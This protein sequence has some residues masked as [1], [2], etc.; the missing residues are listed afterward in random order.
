[1]NSGE[2]REYHLLFGRVNLYSGVTREYYS[3]VDF[4]HNA[5]KTPIRDFKCTFSLIREQYSR[6]T[7]ELV[8]MLP[9]YS[10]V[11]NNAPELLKVLPACVLNRK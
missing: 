2:T 10:R 1:M 11:G 7:P 9:N 8:I 6:I 3:G 4:Y 5:R